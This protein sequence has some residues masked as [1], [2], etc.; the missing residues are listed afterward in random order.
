MT[1]FV[2]KNKS[3]ALKKIKEDYK[4]VIGIESHSMYRERGGFAPPVA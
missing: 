2:D 3:N 1:Q 4:G